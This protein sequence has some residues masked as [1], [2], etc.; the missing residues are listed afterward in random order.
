MSI[1]YRPEIDGLRAIAIVAVIL[2]HAKIT[3]LNYSPF[4]GGFV[5]VDIFFVISGYLITSIILKELVTRNT[6]SFKNF[7][8]RRVRR[9]LPVLLLVM[10]VSLVFGWFY[11]LTNNF[12]DLSKSILYSLGF[13]SNF[14]FLYSQQEYAAESSLL[15]PFLHTW[16]LSV[17]EQF[18]ILFPIILLIIFKYFKRYLGVIFIT[19][20]V[21]SLIIAIWG[22][23]NYP[24]YAFYIIPT[25]V[26]ELLAGSILAYFEII[27]GW[28]ISTKY[29]IF[30]LI[31]PSV[32][33]FLVGYSIMTFDEKI[34]HPS[35]YT[36]LPIIGTCLLILFSHKDEI[37]TKLLS[38]KLFVSI[39]L[40]SYS[41]Y[42][43]HYPI[44]AF[45]RILEFAKEDI[46]KKIT[47]GLIIL[48]LSIISFYFIE[49]PA[50]NKKNRFIFILS[51]ILLSSFLVIIAS[52]LI[53]LNGGYKHRFHEIFDLGVEKELR[54]PNKLYS[55]ANG[56][57]CIFNSEFN[58]TVLIIG[59][60]HME[61]L[62]ANLKD[63]I[64]DK[65]YTFITST[66]GGCLY[67]PGFDKIYLDTNK[68]NEN[69]NN[70]YFFDLERVLKQQKN[71]IIIFGGRLPLYL[72]NDKFD[73]KEGG[74]E[75]GTGIENINIK[76]KYKFVS[77]GKFENIQSSFQ[78]SVYELSKTN[79][80][81]L[82]YPIPE[83]GW[84]VPRKLFNNLP[85]MIGEI[86]DKN[87]I[88]NYLIPKNYITTSYVVYKERAKSSFELLDSIKGENIYRVYPHL[89]F[90]DTLIKERCI[91]HDNK[92]IFY[93]DDDHLSVKGAEIVNK[94]IIS[95]IEKIE[96]KSN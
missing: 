54:S 3:I 87:Y 38:S 5:G 30:N 75:D 51:F 81:I 83:V 89:I 25:R 26:W 2:Y 28:R 70:S 91:T 42:L 47:L 66:L 29:K 78:T 4:Q 80:I 16:S 27:Q 52:S 44:F 60:S 74:V 32:G 12:V 93:S 56:K 50:R 40:I 88:K 86:K 71:S 95:E 46:F 55:C 90:C 94:L 1:K 11:L 41:L 24:L 31:L 84:N 35:W 15:K 14:Y 19:T 57:K 96:K 33:L 65:N 53:I 37:I 63:K 79:N 18:Y 9:I 36:L 21:A 62:T 23:R 48:L 10:A 39:G 59:D 49:K 8:E 76:W 92:N 69:C 82:I 68:I 73:N 64:T 61:K 20:F 85:K 13:S 77:S 7:Y 72:S 34:F 58:K 45:D 43:W 6:F 22:S 17:E 67:F